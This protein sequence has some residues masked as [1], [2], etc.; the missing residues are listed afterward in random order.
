MP[1]RL[2]NLKEHWPCIGQCSL[3]PQLLKGLEP[4]LTGNQFTGLEMDPLDSDM[5]PWSEQ[6]VAGGMNAIKQ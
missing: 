2:N 6:A 4:S 1:A 5:L 3:F